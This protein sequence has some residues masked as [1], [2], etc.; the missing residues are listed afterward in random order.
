MP[1]PK[2]PSLTMSLPGRSRGPNE[3]TN[4]PPAF[5]GKLTTCAGIL[6]LLVLLLG[7]GH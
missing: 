1:F 7:K 2:A 3:F 4:N 6:S 5:V